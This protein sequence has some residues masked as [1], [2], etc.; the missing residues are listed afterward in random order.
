VS[1]N[2]YFQTTAA[3]TAPIIGATINTQT[4][5][6]AVP[7]TSAGPRLRAGF[8]D[9]PVIGVPSHMDHSKRKTVR[10]SPAKP[11][12]AFLLVAP[13]ITIREINVRTTSAMKPE[14][15][16]NLQVMRNQNRSVPNY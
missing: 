13:K 8:T 16:E 9:V 15:R 11:A 10:D 2:R 7:P 12:G 5:A 6:S 14:A 3:I 4:C 1:S